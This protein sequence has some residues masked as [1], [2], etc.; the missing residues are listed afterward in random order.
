MPCLNSIFCKFTA[1]IQTSWELVLK[2][3]FAIFHDLL[4]KILRDIVYI[5]KFWNCKISETKY[6]GDGEERGERIL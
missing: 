6:L 2:Y 3:R 5:G 4:I 1:E